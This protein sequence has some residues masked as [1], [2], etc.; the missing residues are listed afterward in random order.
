MQVGSGSSTRCF[1][2]YSLEGAYEAEIGNTSLFARG[3][4]EIND[5]WTTYLNTSISRVKSFGRYAPVPSSPWPG[6]SIFVP[7][8]SPNHPANRFPDAGYPD[9]PL[10]MRHRF[11]ALGNRDSFTDGQTYSVEWGVEGQLGDIDVNAGIR[12]VDSQYYDLGRNYVVGG[13]AQQAISSGAY[14]IYDPFGNPRSVLDGM[15]ATINRDAKFLAREAYV[16]LSTELFEMPA[17]SVALAVGAEYREEEYKDIYDT[18]QS[19]G[20]IVGSSGNSAFGGRSSKAYYAELAV[21]VAKSI[22]ASLAIRNDRY[23]DYG[24]DLSP[25]VALRWTPMDS[26]VLRASYGEGFRAPTLDIVSAQPAFSA[27]S[28]ADPQTCTAF[29]LAPTCTTQVTTY[30]IANP[31]VESE[32]SEQF[33]FG[34][35]W[36]PVDW[37]NV[38]ADYWNIKL[39]NQ[40]S[41]V[42]IST[43][44]RC[45][46]LGTGLCPSGLSFL[47]VT[48]V[49]PDAS[50]GLGFARAPAGEILYGQTGY[51]NLGFTKTDGIDL[52]VRAQF[53]LGD[54]GR[55][56]SQL[57]MSRTLDYS[58]ASG[59]NVVDSPSVPEERGTLSNTWSYGDFSLT[60]N[61]K[62]IAS[63][64]S[65]QADFIDA[66][67]PDA[68]YGYALRLPSWVTHDLQ[69]NWNT[70]WNGRLTLGALNVADKDPVVDPFDPT[71]RGYDQSLYNG[72][73]RV[74]YFRLMQNL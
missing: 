17:G 58:G 59:T 25:Q 35:V 69:L 33:G 41:F 68:D 38:K 73:G 24:D 26:L 11:A 61:I 62:Y 31:N 16:N 66:F 65:T 57:L 21:P 7:R 23:S 10:F 1:Y 36:D 2:N 47:P 72:Y 37:L 45:L 60:W 40:V 67:G 56:S 5:D 54:W 71:G 18:L 46:E 13:L 30:S 19:S 43:L 39:T 22:E 27:A 20:Q 14:N 44:I 6:G 28:V 42:S 29:G 74:L 34:V 52:N 70:P 51:A 64:R 32:T 53:D 12:R 9:A 50:L 63:T 48:A 49:P 4:Y 8:E 15:I 3:Q 55:L